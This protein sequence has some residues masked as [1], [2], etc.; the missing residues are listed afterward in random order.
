LL[1]LNDSCDWPQLLKQAAA[2]A[3]KNTAVRVVPRT[4]YLSPLLAVGTRNQQ[5][6]D[7]VVREMV[8]DTL[9]AP[10]GNDLCWPATD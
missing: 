2:I 3:N 9:A 6:R 8:I 4:G 7:L 5:V 1:G 10:S